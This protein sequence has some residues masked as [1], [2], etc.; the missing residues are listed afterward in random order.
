MAKELP[1][2]VDTDG[3]EINE[4]V[5]LRYSYL[6]LRRQRLQKV[7]RPRLPIPEYCEELTSKASWK[8]KL[9]F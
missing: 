4:E 2:P 5:R 1:L 7:L 8:W 3:Y 6:D 9:Q